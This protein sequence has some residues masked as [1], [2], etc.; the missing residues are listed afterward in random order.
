VNRTASAY[1]HPLDARQAKNNVI[2]SKQCSS[3]QLQAV[4]HTSRQVITSD[5][6]GFDRWLTACLDYEY[7]LLVM[8]CSK[9]NGSLLGA[10]WN[11]L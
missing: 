6:A 7:K 8:Q 1:H 11:L 4:Q 2:R 10:S 5:K 9:A 3:W